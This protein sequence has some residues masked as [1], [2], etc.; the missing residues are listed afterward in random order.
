MEFVAY[1]A[2]STPLWTYGTLF[3]RELWKSFIEQE[4][5]LRFIAQAEGLS[6]GLSE[7]LSEIKLNAWYRKEKDDKV[8]ED[9][10]IIDSEFKR[11]F[12]VGIPGGIIGFHAFI[13]Y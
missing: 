3:Y 5:L 12:Q 11:D 10:K 7:R 2:S 8:Y 4:N 13:R 9:S 1:I 6:Y